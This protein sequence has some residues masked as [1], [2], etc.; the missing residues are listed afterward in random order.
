MNMIIMMIIII[1]MIVVIMM[2]MMLMLIVTMVLLML[3]RLLPW[4]RVLLKR[5]C[6]PSD[7]NP[8]L[9]QKEIVYNDCKSMSQSRVDITW[10]TSTSSSAL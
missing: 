6:V 4:N 9:R 3:V 1:M 10:L 8:R 5:V 7:I 2:I